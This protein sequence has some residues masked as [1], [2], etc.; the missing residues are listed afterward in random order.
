MSYKVIKS[1]LSVFRNQII[2]SA[3]QS[4]VILSVTGAND[5]FYIFY[6]HVFE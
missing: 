6:L 5:S 3:F 1:F 4:V 2:I